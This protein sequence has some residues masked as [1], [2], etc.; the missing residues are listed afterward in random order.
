MDSVQNQLANSPIERWVK[1]V[2]FVST[3]DLNNLENGL[4]VSKLFTLAELSEEVDRIQLAKRSKPSYHWHENK[5]EKWYRIWFKESDLTIQFDLYLD[6]GN[7]QMNMREIDLE[8]CTT[9]VQ[10]TEWL[11]YVLGRGWSCPEMLWAVMEVI[12]EASVKRF[13]KRLHD[14]FSTKGTLNWVKPSS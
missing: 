7:Y 8:N 5:H 9:S 4:P 12:D 2:E 6:D 13:G 10:F 3:A 14:A 1:A 11:Y